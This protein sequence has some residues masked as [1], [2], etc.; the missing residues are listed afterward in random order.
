MLGVALLSISIV[1]IISHFA[2][3]SF[4]HENTSQ[5]LKQYSVLLREQVK[6][7]L[8]SKQFDTVRMNA[9]KFSSPL[10]HRVTIISKD[11]TVIF[12]SDESN[13]KMENHKDRPEVIAAYNGET[14]TSQR[15]S[16]TFNQE[17]TYVAIPV[18]GKNTE[19]IGVIRGSLPTV[20]L[21][22]ILNTYYFQVMWFLVIFIFLLIFVNWYIS[23]KISRPL[24]IM[25]NQAESFSEGDLFDVS[26]AISSPS[27]EVLALAHSLHKMSKKIKKQFKKIANQ[28]EEREV[29][30]S[31]M[32]E[33]VLS[34]DMKGKIFHWNKPA[35]QLFDVNQTEGL[36][37]HPFED[38]FTNKELRELYEE[39][40]ETH[41][42]QEREIVRGNNRVI[43][44]HGSLLSS[45]VKPQLGVL[46][47]FNDITKLRELE[48]H[49]K[50]F[51]ANV[52]H[53]LRTPL[54]AMQGFLETL[55]EHDIDSREQ[56][57][58]FLK[59]IQKHTSRLSHI[60]EDLLAL[61]NF[62]REQD[63][64][65]IEFHVQDVR[66]VI[67]SSIQLN[68]TKANRKNITVNFN[69]RSQAE[70]TARVN[71]HLLEQAISNLVDNAIKYSPAKTTITVSC[72][73]HNENIDISIK[74][75]GA[76]IP[77]HHLPR[78]FERFYSVD[79]ARSREMG[80]SGLGLSIVK[81]ISSIHSGDVSVQSIVGEGTKFTISIP[82]VIEAQ[83][84]L[85]EEKILH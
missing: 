60:I 38:F 26:F 39:I 48:S 76:G 31:S 3:R 78:L 25:T 19:V 56:R 40:R 66:P 55:L 51:V 29:V 1:L 35:C 8:N 16:P 72:Q 71:A 50:E 64:K 84:E 65:S 22:N 12:D 17:F 21:R 14:G 34:I 68:E 10:K 83:P 44:V 67:T 6:E 27:V 63:D 82:K 36:K 69:D 81:H 20:D 59:I 45:P 62:D 75:Q 13:E 73:F 15:L 70:A 49:R 41:E 2:I 33:G 85:N 80:G 28:K 24:E 52:S 9:A 61:S 57:D 11:G 30:F 77:E 37:G 7:D 47:V 4:F 46:F 58:K 42:I 54:T 5:N 23:Q 74:D 53:E 32:I 43:Q 79:K 18:F